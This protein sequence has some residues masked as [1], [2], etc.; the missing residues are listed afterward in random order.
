VTHPPFVVAKAGETATE[1]S[2]RSTEPIETAAHSPEIFQSA[3][4]YST[5]VIITLCPNRPIR[6]RKVTRVNCGPEPTKVPGRDFR[7]RR[8]VKVYTEVRSLRNKVG[9]LTVLSE[10]LDLFTKML[11]VDR[12]ASNTWP[13]EENW[14]FCSAG[15][16]GIAV[17]VMVVSIVNEQY[18]RIDRSE[19]LKCTTLYHS[20][21]HVSSHVSAEISSVLTSCPSWFFS[22]HLVDPGLIQFS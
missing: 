21:A 11:R 20:P 1:R 2:T 6:R 5:S 8:R 3:H 22:D 13:S 14:R 18:E 10:H 12:V 15:S 17:R 9:S 16:A 7:R 19:R 4:T